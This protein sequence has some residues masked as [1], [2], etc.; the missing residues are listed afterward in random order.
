VF[1]RAIEAVAAAD[2]A[3]MTNAAGA[4]EADEAYRKRLASKIETLASSDM[5]FVSLPPAEQVAR[6]QALLDEEDRAIAGRGQRLLAPPQGPMVPPA[7]QAG[8]PPMI[9][10]GD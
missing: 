9:W 8:P 6:A 2:K 1:A 10:R 7:A 3:R 5:Q 4:S